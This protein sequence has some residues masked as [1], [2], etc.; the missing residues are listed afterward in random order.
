VIASD[1]TEVKANT[2]MDA[3]RRAKLAVP[4]DQAHPP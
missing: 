3:N 1:P 2:S 4:N